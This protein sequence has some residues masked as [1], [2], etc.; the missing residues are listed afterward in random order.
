MCQ[1]YQVELLGS[2]PLD[3]RIRE[4]TDAGK[5]SVVAEPQG[6]IADTY[7]MIARRIAVKVAESAKDHS[8]LFAKI[9]MEND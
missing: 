2:L 9:I 8:E 1:D 6:K 4:H 3:M 5:P 7:R